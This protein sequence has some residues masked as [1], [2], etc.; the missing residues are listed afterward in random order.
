MPRP[1]RLLRERARDDARENPGR[2]AERLRHRA[3]ADQVALE[4]AELFPEITPENAQDVLAWQE[5]RIR[6]LMAAALQAEVLD[7]EALEEALL[8]DGDSGSAWDVR[9]RIEEL[10]A[11]AGR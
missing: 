4:R 7:L 9:R 1:G 6:E 5:A 11:A 10:R 8:A 2:V 3:A